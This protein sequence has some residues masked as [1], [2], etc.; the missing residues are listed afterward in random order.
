MFSA[1]ETRNKKSPEILFSS[2]KFFSYIY[3]KGQKEWENNYENPKV[4]YWKWEVSYGYSTK[5]N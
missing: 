2:F 4:F 1:Q 3:L 5:R